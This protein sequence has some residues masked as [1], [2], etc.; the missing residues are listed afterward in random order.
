MNQYTVGNANTRR[1]VAHNTEE[2]DSLGVGTVSS[3]IGAALRKGREDGEGSI[4]RGKLTSQMPVVVA[5][6]SVMCDL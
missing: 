2:E 3:E 1:E 4:N 6:I 5:L